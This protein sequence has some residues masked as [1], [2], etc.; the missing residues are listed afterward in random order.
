MTL[1]EID[2]AI[3]E[4]LDLETGEVVDAEKL[5]ALQISRDR[6]VEN[7][8]KWIKNT[9]ADAAALKAEED[10]FKRRRQAA[11][12][13]VADLTE[14][15][16]FALGGQPY[17][18]ADKSVSVKTVKNGGKA[19]IVFNEDLEFLDPNGLPEQF[20]KVSVEVD[21]AAVREALEAG[22]VLEFAHIG[23]RGTH[24]VIK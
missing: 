23:D 24:L 21:V 6:K 19:P 11:E 3:L 13:R 2:Q 12:K 14:F 18:A 15:L 22:E 9:K 17:E 8:A 1:Y 10:A 5:E 7:V 16:A 4:C 20:R